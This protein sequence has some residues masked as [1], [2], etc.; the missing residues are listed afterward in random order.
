[1]YVCCSVGR[2]LRL[3]V[4]LEGLEWLVQTFQAAFDQAHSS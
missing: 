4:G 2:L 1:M 3:S